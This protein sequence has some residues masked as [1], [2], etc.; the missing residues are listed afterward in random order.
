MV[1]HYWSKTPIVCSVIFA[2]KFLPHSRTSRCAIRKCERTIGDHEFTC[3]AINRSQDRGKVT[4][5]VTWWKKNRLSILK[6]DWSSRNLLKGPFSALFRLKFL[7]IFCDLYVV[8]KMIMIDVILLLSLDDFFGY[9]RKNL[10]PYFPSI[11]YI[12]N[13]ILSI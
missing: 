8:V 4:F 12:F 10:F 2:E 9:L 13:Y 7:S 1:V 6:L 11:F 5:P 3:A